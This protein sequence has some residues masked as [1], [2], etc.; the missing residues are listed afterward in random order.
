MKTEKVKLLESKVKDYFGSREYD[1][2]VADCGGCLY[3]SM[4]YSDFVPRR[5]VRKY[6][7]SLGEGIYVDSI[8]R[9]YSDEAMRGVCGNLWDKEDLVLRL[10]SGAEVLL[11]AYICS[12]LEDKVL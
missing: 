5:E 6:I 4:T 9:N 3:V 12:L 1:I 10:A 8:E 7:E 11:D 2:E